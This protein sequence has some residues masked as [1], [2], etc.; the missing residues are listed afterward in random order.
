VFATLT[1]GWSPTIVSVV[2]FVIAAVRLPNVMC[3]RPAA[4][5]KLAL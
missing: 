3:R 2:G 1:S 4:V 5:R